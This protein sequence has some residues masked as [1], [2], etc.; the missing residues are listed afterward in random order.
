M[1]ENIKIIPH[2][3]PTM[4]PLE[5]AAA[6]RA[7]GSGWI[8][9]GPE[10]LAFEDELCAYFGLNS[11]HAV[12][13]SSGSAALFLALHAL[14]C[15]GERVGMP[16]YSCSALPNAAAMIGASAVYLDCGKNNPN[17][18]VNMSLD[19]GELPAD[20]STVV[21][22]SMFGLPAVMPSSSA[23]QI[24]E[25]VAQAFGARRN[26]API[27]LRGDIGICSFYATKMIS[28]GGQGGAVISRHKTLIDQIVDYRNF[29]N[30]EDDRRRFNFQMTDVQAAIGRVQNS[31]LNEFIERRE[32]IFDRYKSA[33][34]PLIDSSDCDTAPV[35]YRAVALNDKP[36]ALI[37]HFAQHGIVA[38]NPM[39]E[40]EL[41]DQGHNYPNALELSRKTVS[42][43]IY[44]SMSDEDVTRVINAF[45]EFQTGELQ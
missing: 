34:I 32:K 40:S 33:D 22:P 1:I 5:Q 3:R 15:G 2:N 21:L 12:A 17:I 26:S 41:L 10:T 20:C 16:V 13:V 45:N 18:E 36:D 7:I 30:R 9:T 44:P 23:I 8:A 24:V 37:A 28:S 14:G 42:L 38:I 27:G 11:G 4:G 6:S 29:D 39:R 35:R 31:R 25:D 43:P 19:S